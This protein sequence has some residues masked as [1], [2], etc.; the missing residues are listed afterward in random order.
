MYDTRNPQHDFDYELVLSSAEGK[1][2]FRIP[3]LGLTGTGADIEAAFLEISRLKRDYLEKARAA[4]LLDTLP[5]PGS[6][7]GGAAATGGTTVIRGDIPSFLI[8][9]GIVCLV[10]VLFVGSMGLALRSSIHIPVGKAF[11]TNAETQLH[12]MAQ[13]DGVNPQALAQVQADLRVVVTRYKPIFD[14]LRPLFSD[15]AAKPTPDTK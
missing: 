15:T 10:F 13:G 4:D 8:K 7:S 3:E 5:V 2:V 1:P 12:R 14:E 6:R 9:L 11:W